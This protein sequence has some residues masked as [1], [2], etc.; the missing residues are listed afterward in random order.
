MKL[1]DQQSLG[2]PITP[3]A[4]NSVASYNNAEAPAAAMFDLGK[5]TNQ[6]GENLQNIVDR[7]NTMQAI[8]AFAIGVDRLAQFRFPHE[9]EAFRGSAD[10]SPSSK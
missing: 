8:N 9:A 6:A 10:V 7:A 4:T 1:P 2:N 3:E 5:M